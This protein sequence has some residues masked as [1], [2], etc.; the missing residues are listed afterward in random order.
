MGK[1]S[2]FAGAQLAKLVDDLGQLLA[3]E[4]QVG[5]SKFFANFVQTGYTEILTLQQ[6]VL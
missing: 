3:A 2:C 4:F 5:L 6:I 1:L